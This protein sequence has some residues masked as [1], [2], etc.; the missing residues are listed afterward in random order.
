MTKKKIEIVEHECREQ[1]RTARLLVES[2]EKDGRRRVTG[3]EC[4]NP[5]LQT[6]EPWD[7]DWSCMDEVEEQA[8]E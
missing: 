2:E 3:V 8:G 4:D 5:K 7:C 1:G 6:L